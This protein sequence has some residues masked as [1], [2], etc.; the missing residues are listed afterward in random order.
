MLIINVWENLKN[1]ANIYLA[2]YN[3]KQTKQ[4]KTNQTHTP[5]EQNQQPRNKPMN[6]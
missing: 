3:L 6:V 1:K 5:I 2:H 4:N